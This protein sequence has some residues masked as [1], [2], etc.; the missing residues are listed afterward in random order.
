M[1]QVDCRTAGI[2]LDDFS[3]WGRLDKGTARDWTR[4]AMGRESTRFVA[5]PVFGGVYFQSLDDV[6]PAVLFWSIRQVRAGGRLQILPEGLDGL[7]EALAEG[8]DVRLEEPALDVRRT[9]EGVR[10]ETSTGVYEAD[11][12][13][14]AVPAPVACGIVQTLEPVEASLLAVQY[15]ST[16][17]VTF[18]GAGGWTERPEFAGIHAI[19]FGSDESDTVAS[20]SV[21]SGMRPRGWAGD[22]ALQVFLQ[23][24]A[25]K[26]LA[27]EPDEAAVAAAVGGLADIAPG[28]AGLALST[29]VQRWPHALPTVSPGRVGAVTDYRAGADPRL[30][31]AGDLHGFPSADTAI[32]SGL[33]AADRVLA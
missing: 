23:E 29:E 6:S 20:I 15:S 13:I 9:A 31:F 19:H 26:R 21:E 17:G 7:T 25:A 11:A 4:R 33:W 18:R 16:I 8:L 5:Q 1:G 24:S 12:A 30:L 3:Q 32:F 22:D 28:L 14:V 2:E 10:V 27:R